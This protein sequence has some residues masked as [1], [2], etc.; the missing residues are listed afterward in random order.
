[1]RR[2]LVISAL[3]IVA[4][5]AS[6]QLRWV[7]TEWNFGTIKEADGKVTHEFAFRNDGTDTVTVKRTAS[8]CGCTTANMPNRVILPGDTG[9]L[10]VT[11][12]PSYRPGPFKKHVAVYTDKGMCQ[13][14]IS[15]KV[16]PE[17][18]TVGRL[19]PE[20]V[21]CL[22]L[23]AR[24]AVVGDVK[25]GRRRL[26]SVIAYNAGDDTLHLALDCR[27]KRLSA[28]AEPAS[29][30]PGDLTTISVTLEAGRTDE[31]GRVDDVVT[32]SADGKPIGSIA[33]TAQIVAAHPE[34]V[35][36][37][38]AP[39]LRLAADRVDFSP[40]GTKKIQRTVTI[41]NLGKAD[42]H[43]T[44]AGST[45]DAVRVVKYPHRVKPGK[46]ASICVELD[47]RLMAD[48]RL[49]NSSVVV[50]TNDPLQGTVQIRTVGVAEE[51][52]EKQ[53]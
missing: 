47:P 43:I 25:Q 35:D 7:V 49:L 13:L 21:G 9:L 29:V 30:A 28:V 1:M 42:L 51:K 50:F 46:S 32:L 15:G 4:A 27:D 31:T 19:F 40:I 44:G 24:T 14:Q 36:Y 5:L 22:R 6:A 52:N 2:S 26:A 48:D 8:S 11:F 38:A 23:T 18:E 41:E 53:K 16:R 45:S 17:G 10:S 20:K 3:A 34:K 33:A 37:S 12:N 39:R